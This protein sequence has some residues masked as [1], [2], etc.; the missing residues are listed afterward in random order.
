MA[1]CLILNKYTF[2]KFF[3]RKIKTLIVPYLFFLLLNWIGCELLQYQL[4]PPHSLLSVLACGSSN[5][6]WFIYV[7]F[8]V[9]IIFFLLVK[10]KE[11]FGVNSLFVVLSIIS[12]YLM[13]L[14]NI[15][16]PY[17]L[18]VIGMAIFFFYIDIKLILNKSYV[19]ILI[20]LFI[21]SIY[22]A[23]KQNP[24]L[25]MAANIWGT[26][27]PTLFV[28]FLGIFLTI[29]YAKIFDKI[30]PSL[31]KKV[32]IYIG[33]NSIVVVGMSQII[34]MSMKKYFD[35]YNVPPLISSLSRHFFLWCLLILFI[36]LFTKYIPFFIGKR[37][38]KK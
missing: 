5:A 25:D 21:L 16:L 18:E 38:E 6:T 14:Y 33:K 7:L 3:C 23:Y 35:L 15:H 10:I 32:I 34:L 36:H 28:A 20:L 31:L 27:I 11:K 19:G 24:R 12:S 37:I 17:K 13:Y 29:Q 8:F 2:K 30:L 22:L 26:G 9:E 4:Y 1:F